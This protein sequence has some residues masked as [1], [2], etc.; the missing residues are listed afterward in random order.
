MMLSDRMKGLAVKQLATEIRVTAVVTL[1]ISQGC[2]VCWMMKIK[3]R[4]GIET[5]ARGNK[6]Q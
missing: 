4:S 6:S 2:N 5:G 3:Q 1:D